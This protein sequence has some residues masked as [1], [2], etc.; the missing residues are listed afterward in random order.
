MTI[1]LDS[2]DLRVVFKGLLF[3]FCLLFYNGV[4]HLRQDIN[5]LGSEVTRQSG[6]LHATIVR[7]LYGF[8]QINFQHIVMLDA[9][10]C[11]LDLWFFKF[12]I[13]LMIESLP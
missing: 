4:H 12:G 2:E 9:D 3:F 13:L 6:E 7:I 5:H 8:I 11:N 1:S 10:P